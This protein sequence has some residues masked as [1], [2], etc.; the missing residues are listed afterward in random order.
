MTSSQPS[1][2]E[3][4]AELLRRRRARTELAAFAQAIDIPGKPVGEDEDAWLFRSIECTVAAH[5][6]LLLNELQRVSETPY[7]RLMVFMPPGSAKSTYGSVVFPAWFMGRAIDRRV[8]LTSYGSELARRHGRRARQIARSQKYRSIFGATISTE[9]SAADEWALTNG[10]EYLAGG[11]LSG[12]TGNRAHGLLIDDPVKGR[13]EADSKLIRD[14]TR[15]A[16]EDDLKTRLFPGAWVVLIQ[17]RWH[18]DDLAGSI[19]PENYAGESGDILCRDGQVWRVLCLAAKAER[20][21]DPLGR[22]PGEYLWPEWFDRNHWRQF[23]AVPRTWS[24][25]YQQR[26]APEEGDY[27]RAEWLKPYLKAPDRSTLKI[28]GASDYAVT[29]DGGDYTVHGVI[30][31]DP[32]DNMWLL[33]LWRGQTGSDQWVE[34]FCD[35]VCDWRPIGWAEESGQIKAGVGP[36]LE[37]RMRERN[38]FVFRETFPTRGDKAVRAQSIRGR[39]A[40]NGLHVPINAPWFEAFKSELLTF[41]AGRNDDQVDALG[42]VGQLLDKMLKGKPA[43][44]PEPKRHLMPG[45]VLLPGP[46]SYGSKKRMA[47]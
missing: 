29:A 20:R 37:K 3:A 31:I 38:A 47:I 2:Q 40:L 19:L 1:P 12:I 11:I 9:T 39:M 43:K 22:P 44:T 24:A 8:I 17:T 42:L 4:A 25:L 34:A 36:F 14:K 26:P 5:H 46:P 10:S 18:E 41:P 13:E 30:G 6:V 23:E 32:A 35:L 27:F 7:G 33:D 21:D 28:Y 15:A 45:Q 16:Y